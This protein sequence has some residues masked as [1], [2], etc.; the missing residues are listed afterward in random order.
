LLV[1][2]LLSLLL[3]LLLLCGLGDTINV[4]FQSLCFH[5][6]NHFQSNVQ[7]VLQLATYSRK[8]III[9]DAESD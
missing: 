1:V 2:L 5:L 6:T 7:K 9:L 3:L 8:L 4:L